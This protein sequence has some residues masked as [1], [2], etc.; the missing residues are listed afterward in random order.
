[1]RVPP[2]LTR[3]SDLIHTSAMKKMSISEFKV[4]CIAVLRE[5]QRTGEPVVITRRGRPVARIEPILEGAA[6][7][8]LGALRMIGSCPIHTRINPCRKG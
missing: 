8:S 4:K 2:E 5:A 6:Q 3:S 7:R 1:M